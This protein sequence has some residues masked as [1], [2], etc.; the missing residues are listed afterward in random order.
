MSNDEEGGGTVIFRTPLAS[1]KFPSARG[2]HSTVLFE[3]RLVVFG[4]HYHKGDGVFVYE[5]DT[6][7]LNLRTLKWKLVRTKGD[8]PRARYGHSATVFG[9]EMYVFGGRGSGGKNFRDMDC[10][11]L[12]TMTWRK[13]RSA[14][15]LPPGR[16]GHSATLI[17]DKIV[18]F[19]GF[20]GK[21]TIDDLWV[22]NIATTT[23][24]RPRTTGRGPKSRHGHTCVLS[25]EGG[26]VVFGGYHVPGIMKLPEYLNEVRELNLQ[27]MHWRRLS[28]SGAFP[29]GRFGHTT[30]LHGNQ[31]VCFGGYQGGPQRKVGVTEE[32]HP[33]DVTPENAEDANEKDD[34]K[35]SYFHAMDMDELDWWQPSSVG[36]APG[37]RYGHS[38]TYVGSGHFLIFG[39]W[40]G[41]RPLNSLVDMEIPI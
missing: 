24:M 32:R 39:G 9:D 26:L 11:N 30:A 10:L 18:I 27:E 38:M 1:G 8:V 19:G 25:E 33:Q 29:K 3:Q 7:V 21:R 17:G 36:E 35:L 16:S 41:T 13:I 12:K 2:G 40:D 37:M 6:Y 5:N 23:W 20:D 22:F 28:P 4:G 14:N 34:G 15:A 31:M